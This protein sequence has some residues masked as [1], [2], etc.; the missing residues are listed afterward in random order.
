MDKID[1]LEPSYHKGLNMI[2]RLGSKWSDK[3][4]VGDK[5]QITSNMCMAV[6]T[7]AEVIGTCLIPFWLIP[8]EML[9][10]QHDPS[11]TNIYGLNHAMKRAYGDKFSTDS[12]CSVVLFAV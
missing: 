1:F 10:Y 8:T 12:L 6:H 7:D 4:N 2:V 9:S 5:V 3:L 11:C